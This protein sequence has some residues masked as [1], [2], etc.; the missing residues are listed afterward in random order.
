MLSRPEALLIYG[1][2]EPVWRELCRL[3]CFIHD[4]YWHHDE[5][6]HVSHRQSY[7]AKLLDLHN[8]SMEDDPSLKHDIE[9]LSV[10]VQHG[11]EGF[12]GREDMPLALPIPDDSDL[13]EGLGVRD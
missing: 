5:A 8:M 10:V 3:S 11:L 2:G 13:E 7:L 4:I 6:G 9:V 1:I 12:E